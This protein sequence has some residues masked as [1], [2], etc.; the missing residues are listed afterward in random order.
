MWFPKVFVL[1]AQAQIA[2]SSAT[3]LAAKPTKPSKPTV[4]F[5][6]HG[7]KPPFGDGLS[8]DGLQRA[9]CLRNVFGKNSSFAIDLIMAQQPQSGM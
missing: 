2:L 4:F 8:I 9:Q 1:A 5:I 6:R 7:E 3:T